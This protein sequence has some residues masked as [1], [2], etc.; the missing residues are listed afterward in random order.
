MSEKHDETSTLSRIPPSSR[1]QPLR[2]YGQVFG[3][4]NEATSA[5]MHDRFERFLAGNREVSDAANSAGLPRAIESPSEDRLVAI[6][7]ALA[8]TQRRS[9]MLAAA[10][11]LAL[12][13][14]LASL[15]AGLRTRGGTGTELRTAK[16][17]TTQDSERE[18]VLA[19]GSRAWISPRSTIVV[20]RDD[21]GGGEFDLV[22]GS[23]L[24]DVNQA[25]G[26]HWI[27]HVGDYD[28]SAIG[29]RFR[30]RHTG[31]IPDV[32]VYEGIVD[33]IGGAV[34]VEAVRVPAA[35]GRLA[36]V[37]GSA[38]LRDLDA[39]VRAALLRCESVPEDE[40]SDCWDAF[41]VK[42]GERVVG[43]W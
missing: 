12:A 32:E 13:L 3:E 11:V 36:R 25:E 43:P 22:R 41:V 14:A 39:E 23:I 16:V 17:V 33:V 9:W 31:G 37:L 20:L 34:G 5:R 19:R 4:P 2:D 18:V 42:H 24:L 10:A 29:T 27:V 38:R 28:V 21:A 35:I 30:V 8:R 1:P 26:V 15:F 7:H 40:A 6:E